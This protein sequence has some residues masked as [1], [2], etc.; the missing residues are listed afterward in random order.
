M[1]TQYNIFRK[2]SSD[3]SKSLI[4]TVAGL[5]KSRQVIR[6]LASAEALFVT[7]PNLFVEKNAVIVQS[8]T[9]SI[10]FSIEKV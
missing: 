8:K 10:E 9:Y 6:S 1:E 5:S 7:S 2:H 4:T 3:T